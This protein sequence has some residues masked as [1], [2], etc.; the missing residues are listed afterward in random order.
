MKNEDFLKFL[1]FPSAGNLDVC[2]HVED[3]ETSFFNTDSHFLTS[4]TSNG[5]YVQ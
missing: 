3:F 2:A 5:T 4:V 1:A